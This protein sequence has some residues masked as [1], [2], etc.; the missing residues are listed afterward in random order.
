MRYLGGKSRLAPAIY[1]LTRAVAPNADSITDLFTGSG[2]LSDYFKSKGFEVTTN[3]LLYFSFAVSR[4]TLA[5][6]KPQN[7]KALRSYLGCDPF[8][9]LNSIALPAPDASQSIRLAYSPDSDPERRY[10]TRDNALRID[11]ARQQIDQWKS[12]KLIDTDGYYYLLAGIISGVP[13]VSNITGTYGAFLKYWDK[14]ALNPYQVAPVEVLNNGK[15]NKSFNLDALSLLG[16][17]SGQVLYL[18]PPYNERQYLP[19]YHVLETVALYDNPVVKGV[20]GQRPVG[21]GKSELCS[22]KTALSALEEIIAAAQ[23]EH[24]ILSYNNEGVI[25]TPDLTAML[26]RHAAPRSYKLHEIPYRRYK[27]KIPNHAEGLVE[28]LH[29]IR[30][31][32]CA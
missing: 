2:A 30:K 21:S 12:A 18:D 25:P 22:K 20:T 24:I 1:D 3:D 11:F 28:Q 7:F 17:V 10:L 16:K 32:V 5:I 29:Y 13:S 9:Y 8:E 27:N 14:R 26:R 31:P 4:G 6:N 19:N 15:K 23:F